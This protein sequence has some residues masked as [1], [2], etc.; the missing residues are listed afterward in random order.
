MA[1]G[2]LAAGFQGNAGVGRSGS[3]ISGWKTI[4]ADYPDLFPDAGQRE[5]EW[6]ARTGIYP[7]HGTIVVKE[8]VLSEYPWVARSLFDA[9]SKAKQM[10]LASL[11]AG[12]PPDSSKK[13]MA[14]LRKIVGDDPLPYGMEANMATV[15]ALEET[16]FRQCLT[17]RR[18]SVGEL[19]IDPER[20]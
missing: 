17:P 20:T 2:E 3:P 12:Q 5:A 10:W 7:I 6:Y 8:S 1:A 19:F 14:D 11:G 16:A 4:E 15:R 13:G 18:M 9:F